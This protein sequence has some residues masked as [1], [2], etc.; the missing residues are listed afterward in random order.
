VDD[1]IT[2][3]VKIENNKIKNTEPD[4]LKYEI[5]WELIEAL[6]LEL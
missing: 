1:S 5:P 3:I 6:N 2:P 4:N